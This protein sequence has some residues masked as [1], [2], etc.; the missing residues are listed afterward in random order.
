[1]NLTA[2]PA[3][4]HLTITLVG[5]RTLAVT[6]TGVRSVEKNFARQLIQIRHPFSWIMIAVTCCSKAKVKHLGQFNTPFK[7]WTVTDFFMEF[8]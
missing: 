3:C 8:K 5:P 6:F 7:T 2:S 1:M 4:F